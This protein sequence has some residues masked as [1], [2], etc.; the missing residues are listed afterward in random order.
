MTQ[1][2]ILDLT[3]TGINNEGEG[4]VRTPDGGFVLFVPGALPGE[5]VTARVVRLRK[6]YGT[7]KVLERRSDS[8][9]RVKPR[10][11]AFGRCGGCQLQH[12]SYEAQLRLKTQTVRDAL[13]R[14]GGISEPPVEE[15]VPSPSQWGYRN[16]A[17]LPVQRCSRNSFTAG[18]YR[19]RSHEI[20]PFTGCP[21]LL[22]R[23]EKLALSTVAELSDRSLNGYDERAHKNATNFIRHIVFRSARFTGDSLCGIVTCRRPDKSESAKLRSAAKALSR[24]SGGTVLNVNAREGNFIRAA[25]FPQ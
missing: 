6:N 18:F 9:D 17:A 22:P 2:D 8:P 19:S 4:V 25:I 13:R 15:C 21:V 7:A 20:I 23:L 11:P 14:I 5:E 1:G 24:I 12:M 10:C 3:I 16:K